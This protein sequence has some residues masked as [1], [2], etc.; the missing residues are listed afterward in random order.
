MRA[1]RTYGDVKA[2]HVITH[3]TCRIRV[4]SAVK[5]TGTGVGCMLITGHTLGGT[6]PKVFTFRAGFLREVVIHNWLG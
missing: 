6:K 2:G 4:A 3:G 1:W 5:L